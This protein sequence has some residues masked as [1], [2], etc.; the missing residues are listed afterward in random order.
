[1]GRKRWGREQ[2]QEKAQMRQEEAG[3]KAGNKAGKEE[4]R[5]E[6]GTPKRREQGWQQ[7]GNNKTW[8]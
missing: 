8:P 6:R 1:M 4:E 2:Q 5:R 3:E 7:T